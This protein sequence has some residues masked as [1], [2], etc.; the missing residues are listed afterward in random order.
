MIN[1]LQGKHALVTGGAHG[2]GGAVAE[3]L[4]AA[5]AQVTI[6]GRN[7]EKL[8]ATASRL[9][10]CRAYELDVADEAAVGKVFA[11]AVNAAGPIEVLI[12]N[13]GI[14]GSSP[15]MKIKTD[16]VRRLMEVNLIGTLTCSQ[17]VLPGMLDAGWG[18]IVN[19]ASLAGLMGHAY[20]AP[21]CASKHA[22]VGLTRALAL[23]VARTEITVNA[24]CPGYVE[25]G[26]VEQAISAITSKTGRTAEEARTSLADM[27]P[28]G[29]IVQPEGVAAT[30]MWLCQPGAES[31]TGQSIAMSGGQW[32]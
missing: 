17:Q 23:E 5:G 2:I 27:N 9:A 8:D 10:G 22:V 21:Y 20:I 7:T 19:I 31:V 30:V 26:M 16:D 1:S 6:T 29:Q 4:H 32:M 24:V 13:A 14:A 12:N 15:F 28:Q 25:T 18:R 11:T 3:A